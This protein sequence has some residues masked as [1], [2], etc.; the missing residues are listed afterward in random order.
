[1]L[2]FFFFHYFFYVERNSY[3]NLFY[4]FHFNTSLAYII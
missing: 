4:I 1:M 2:H 3:S